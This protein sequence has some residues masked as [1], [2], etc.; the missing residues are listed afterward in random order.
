M[1]SFKDIFE[2][3]LYLERK[4]FPCYYGDSL[5]YDQIANIFKNKSFVQSRP[6][7]DDSFEAEYHLI[8]LSELICKINPSQPLPIR[9]LLRI[10]EWCATKAIY[11]ND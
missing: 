11:W 4:G 1:K 3:K 6:L 5:P 2:A 8:E 7:K 10:I 9:S